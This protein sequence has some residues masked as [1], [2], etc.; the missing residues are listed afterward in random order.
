MHNTSC[1]VNLTAAVK[2]ITAC[3]YKTLQVAF[4]RWQYCESVLVK[5]IVLNTDC[6][7]AQ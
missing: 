1:I 7:K 6:E 4:G 2:G 5:V 3:S